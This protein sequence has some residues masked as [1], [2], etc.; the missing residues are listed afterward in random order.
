VDLLAAL[1]EGAPGLGV[2]Q[3]RVQLA[4]EVLREGEQGGH[5]GVGW[6]W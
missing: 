2:G 3:Q 4:H 5:R 6:G 1:G